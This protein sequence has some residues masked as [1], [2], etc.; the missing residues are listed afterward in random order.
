MELLSTPSLVQEWMKQSGLSQSAAAKRLGLT[1][2][3]LRRFLGGEITHLRTRTIRRLATVLELPEPI[4]RLAMLSDQARALGVELDTALVAARGS[5]YLDL[6]SGAKSA[7]LELRAAPVVLP[8]LPPVTHD[9]WTDLGDR[10]T[11]RQKLAVLMLIR[12]PRFQ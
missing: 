7:V 2:P 5:G 10:L 9:D 4:I 3:W 11:Q 12:N 1:T 6:V 8:P